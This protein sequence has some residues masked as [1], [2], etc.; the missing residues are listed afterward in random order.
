MGWLSTQTCLEVW[1]S[2]RFRK[3]RSIRR[4]WLDNIRHRVWIQTRIEDMIKS[5]EHLKIKMIAKRISRSLSSEMRLCWNSTRNSRIT[6]TKQTNKNSLITISKNIKNRFSS[7]TQWTSFNQQVVQIQEVNPHRLSARNVSLR[8]YWRSMEIP[9]WV[10][11]EF[12]I[13]RPTFWKTISSKSQLM[14]K[15]K[16]PK[17]KRRRWRCQLSQMTN[18]RTIICLSRMLNLQVIQMK[19]STA[20]QSMLQVPAT[21]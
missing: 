20:L 2:R 15:L 16:S 9:A 11:L 6:Q 12:H 10:H 18:S 19:V 17:D 21:S 7:R 14:L 3:E 4:E 5:L 1:V 13:I 8:R